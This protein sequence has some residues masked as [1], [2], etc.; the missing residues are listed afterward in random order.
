[1]PCHQE[2]VFEDNVTSLCVGKAAQKFDLLKAAGGVGAMWWIHVFSVA[3]LSLP[4]YQGT[5]RETC[6][7]AESKISEK[8]YR[9]QL[10]HRTEN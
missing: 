10:D 1:M 6:F 3:C 2:A 9:F 4:P 7:M 8:Q 5:T